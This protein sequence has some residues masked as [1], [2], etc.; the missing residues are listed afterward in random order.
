MGY[1]RNES[2]GGFKSSKNRP[3][4]SE[5]D[6]SFREA[7]GHD[8]NP[9]DAHYDPRLCRKTAT[10]SYSN[11]FGWRSDRYRRQ[12]EKEA[13]GADG[14]ITAMDEEVKPIGEVIPNVEESGGINIWQIAAMGLAV[15][16]AF[17]LVK[18][19]K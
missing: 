17:T 4:G 2:K 11:I 1:A 7:E 3:V 12:M 18:M 6:G 16:G 13:G 15:V 8:R 5:S 9:C 14:E 19:I 10:N